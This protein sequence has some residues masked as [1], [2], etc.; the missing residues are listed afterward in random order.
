[1]T[2]C[3]ARGT[4]S[5]FLRLQTFMLSADAVLDEETVQRVLS[6]GHSRIPVYEGSNRCGKAAC[7]C[8]LAP[9]PP[10]P[11]RGGTGQLAG[12]SGWVCWRNKLVVERALRFRGR[13]GAII[14][15]LFCS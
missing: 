1:M 13:R 11:L 5:Q 14:G 10:S 15:A 9:A 8:V 12:E 2:E 4:F 3:P 6:S 7:L